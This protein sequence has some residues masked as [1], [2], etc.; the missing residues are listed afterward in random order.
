MPDPARPETYRRRILVAVSGKSPA[1]ITETL[2]AL[3]VAREPAWV[4]TE[5]HVVTTRTGRD[6]VQRRLLDPAT[7]AFRALCREHRLADV[8]FDAGNVHVVNDAHG[9]ELDDIVTSAD[10]EAMADT[11]TRLLRGFAVADD[12]ALHVSLAGGR[13]T[14]SYYAGYA[15]SL[16]GRAQDR[17]S[18]VLVAPDYETAPTFNFPTRGSFE[19]TTRG[20]RTL[21]ARDATVELA[22]IPFVRLADGRPHRLFDGDASFSGEVRL[23]QKVLEPPN[24]VLQLGDPPVLQLSGEPVAM[25]Q[26]YLRFYA[27][28]LQARLEDRVIPRGELVKAHWTRDVRAYLYRAQRR[29]YPLDTEPDMGGFLP[30]FR[31][32]GMGPWFTRCNNLIKRALGDELARPYLVQSLKANERNDGGYY[33]LDRLDPARIHILAA[34]ATP[35]RA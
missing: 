2:Y 30:G 13:K 4:P 7:G 3:A 25:T 33:S 22:E 35:R 26:I 28:L 15:L 21:D 19:V 5:V 14:M 11:I 23:A 27:M 20:G 9:D 29:L 10:N 32:D 16:F 8:A 17:L 34:G 12:T 6:L 18:H 24:V 31:L 1:I